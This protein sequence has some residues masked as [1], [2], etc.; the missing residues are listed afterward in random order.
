VRGL[1]GRHVTANQGTPNA[2]GASAWPV[3]DATTHTDLGTINTTLGSPAQQTGAT[4]GLAPG[5]ANVGNLNPATHTQCSS[6]CT[7]LVVKTSAGVLYS[8]NVSADSTLSG[9]AWWVLVYDAT[10]KPADG[11]V[12][13]AKCY[14]MPS[15]AMALNGAFPAGGAAFTTGITFAVSTTGCFTSTSSTHAFIAA[16]YQ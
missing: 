16:D 3:T 6:L 7:S 13:P 1:H 2:G 8:F 9:A 11:A 10:S 4:V 15:G 14:A 5:S 12:T